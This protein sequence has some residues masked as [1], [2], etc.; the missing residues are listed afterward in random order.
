MVAGVHDARAGDE[1]STESWYHDDEGS[2]NFTLGIKD[3]E[4]CC[5]IEGEVEKTGKGDCQA[6]E[7]MADSGWGSIPLLC[8][9]GKLLKP[10]CR[11]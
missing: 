8:P 6:L 10:S 4:L 7:K 1:C 3:M 11:M 2:P 9:E 5:K